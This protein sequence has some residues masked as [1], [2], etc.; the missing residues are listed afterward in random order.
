MNV[1]KHTSSMMKA[2]ICKFFCTRRQELMPRGIPPS[3]VLSST[4]RSKFHMRVV[5]CLLNNKIACA[6]V[7]AVVCAL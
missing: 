1:P 4:Q 2:K 3:R 6:L 7:A 5:R